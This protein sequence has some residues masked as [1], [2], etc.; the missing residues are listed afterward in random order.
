MLRLKEDAAMQR[1][2]LEQEKK[3]LGER[4]SLLEETVYRLEVENRKKK[5]ALDLLVAETR[6]AE[7]ERAAL[8]S[9]ETA[10]M[11]SMA[12]ARERFVT[13]LGAG[14]T[15]PL[16]PLDPKGEDPEEEVRFFIE[17]LLFHLDAAD[18]IGREVHSFTAGDGMTEEAFVTRVGALALL[19]HNGEGRFFFLTPREDQRQYMEAQRVPGFRERRIVRQFMEGQGFLLP[20]DLSGGSVLSGSSGHVAFADRLREGGL[21]IW[22][23]VLLGVTGGLLFVQRAF[24]LFRLSFSHGRTEDLIGL[25]LEGDRNHRNGK[26]RRSPAFDVVAKAVKMRHEPPAVREQ[27]V[28][29][30]VASWA[31]SME[32]GLASLGVMAALAPML[33]LLGTVTG[34]MASFRVMS[35][36]G[37]GDIRLMSGGIS[38]ALV[39]TQWGL[40]VAV[41]LMLAHHLLARRAERL[42]LEAEDR[43]AEALVLLENDCHRGAGKPARTTGNG[44][45]ESC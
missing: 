24:F 19:G 38:E 22:P 37:A 5:Q 30:A 28:E 7:E 6:R 17:S 14:I 1:V 43:G 20:V 41:P 39:T 32:K 25:A 42:A 12:E 27:A 33:G 2:L 36:M 16:R 29:G 8:R 45:E 9:T 44:S 26:S 40:A 10:V 34:M 18:G 23:I 35:R 31:D 11:A 13:L 3:A 15:L 4:R 21:L